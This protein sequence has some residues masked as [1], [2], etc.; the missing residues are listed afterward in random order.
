MRDKVGISDTIRQS[1]LLLGLALTTAFAVNSFSPNGIPLLGEWDTSKG[2]ITANPDS[3]IVDRDLEIE[4]VDAAKKFF[5][6][7]SAVF[8]DARSQDDFDR[9]H[10]EGAL[11]VPVNDFES[12]LEDL[13]GRY[14]AD[15]Y[16]IT[17]CSGRECEDS[18]RLAHKLFENGYWEV[19][20]FIDGFPA[21]EAKGYPVEKVD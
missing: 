6:H 9:G 18:H 13:K 20:V 19:S 12:R 8:L 16:F 4:S 7:R 10:I 2:V 11:S 15:T 5:D 14:E 3:G 17:Y 1:L 21:W